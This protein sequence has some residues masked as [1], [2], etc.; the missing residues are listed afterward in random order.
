MSLSHPLPSHN[1]SG[2]RLPITD[3]SICIRI[4]NYHNIHVLY[5]HCE[6][7][8]YQGLADASVATFGHSFLENSIPG[9][10]NISKFSAVLINNNFLTILIKSQ[11]FYFFN[12]IRSFLNI[13]SC[14]SS[15]LLIIF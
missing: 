9:R 12:R 10:L 2:M 7:S 6:R 8:D 3:D 14:E 4:I 11:T 5:I 13:C 1:H 15:P